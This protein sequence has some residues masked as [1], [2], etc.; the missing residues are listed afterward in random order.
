MPTMLNNIEVGSDHA[1]RITHF[2]FQNF[3]S[4]P[5][6]PQNM[7]EYIEGGEFIMFDGEE[8]IVTDDGT[9]IHP[10][11]TVPSHV[12][13]GAGVLLEAG[14]RFDVS[15]NEAADRSRVVLE[16]GVRLRDTDV[17]EGVSIG[18]HSAVL[19]RS[20]GKGAMIGSY[21][22]SGPGVVIQQNAV[23]E[24]TAKLDREVSIGSESYVGFSSRLG[25][26]TI[27]SHHV[28]IGDHVTIGKFTGYS[29]P[30]E[31]G[32]VN[33]DGNVLMPGRVVPDH[34]VL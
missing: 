25:Y 20:V 1:G 30:G 16:D 2:T 23:V 19:A 14:T 22:R 31:I 34:T 9:L 21:V 33:R 17:H 27:V 5:I 11:V 32:G 4:T 18:H 15:D 12:L 7:F 26:R 28:L 13:L 24:D 10:S 29:G 3:E 8:Y 6:A